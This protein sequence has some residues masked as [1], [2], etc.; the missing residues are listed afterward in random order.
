MQNKRWLKS[1]FWEFYF[2]KYIYFISTLEISELLMKR[3]MSSFERE[4]VR[5]LDDCFSV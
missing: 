3:E 5:S 2:I 4:C 1:D